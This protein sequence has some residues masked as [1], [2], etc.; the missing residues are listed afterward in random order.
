MDVTAT[1]LTETTR[2][3]ASANQRDRFMVPPLEMQTTPSI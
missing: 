2:M 3:A 1:V